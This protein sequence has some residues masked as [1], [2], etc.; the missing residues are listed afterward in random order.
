[1]NRDEAEKLLKQYKDAVELGY[2]REQ[3][4]I[5]KELLTALTGSER[6]E[7]FCAQ[8]VLEQ[9]AKSSKTYYATYT[10]EEWGAI[11]AVLNFVEGG[12]WRKMGD[13]PNTASSSQT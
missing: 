12:T 8:E 13:R 6:P 11:R 9:F 10:A 7:G 5:K 3:G 1:M 4:I 2:L